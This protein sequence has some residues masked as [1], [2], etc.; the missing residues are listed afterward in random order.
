MDRKK[1]IP[2]SE[3]RG[4][5]YP[6]VFL[7][8]SGLKSGGFQAR[9]LYLEGPDPPQILKKTMKNQPPSG[10]V[11]SRAVP[12]LLEAG[13]SQRRNACSRCMCGSSAR[14][15]GISK[16]DGSCRRPKEGTA[17]HGT[18]RRSIFG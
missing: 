6:G 3:Y 9:F 4:Q 14:R 2:G 10:A 17:P 1:S 5:S 8:E 13:T 18:A 12:C 11:P 7:T 15:S 16:P